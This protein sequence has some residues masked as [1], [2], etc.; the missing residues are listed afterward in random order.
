MSFL[1]DKS[2]GGEMGNTDPELVKFP[3]KKLQDG[4]SE[5][6]GTT[7]V[8][9]GWH[10][11]YGATILI[12]L[13]SLYAVEH[14][15]CSIRANGNRG[16]ATFKA[17]VSEDGENFTP[18]GVWDGTQSVLD[19]SESDPKRNVEIVVSSENPSKARYVKVFL[20]TWD[21]ATADRVYNQLVI[22]ELAVWG[23]ALPE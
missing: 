10:S 8:Y 12:D 15:G 3:T 20:S 22:G 18:L 11:R 9:G 14:V 6:I 13:K 23:E 7:A 1:V 5:R 16:A 4:Y 17:M 21:E 2:L 19:A